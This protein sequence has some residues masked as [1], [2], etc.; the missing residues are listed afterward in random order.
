MSDSAVA[1]NRHAE[2]GTWCPVRLA[3]DPTERAALDELVA[4]FKCPN[5]TNILPFL[6]LFCHLASRARAGYSLIYMPDDTVKNF[7]T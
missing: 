6:T 7:N 1:L 3:M 4:S 5:L 2:P